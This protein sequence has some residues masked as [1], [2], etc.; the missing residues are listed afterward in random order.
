MSFATIEQMSARRKGGFDDVQVAQNPTSDYNYPYEHPSRSGPAWHPRQWGRKTRIGVGVGLVVLLVVVIVGAVVGSEKNRYPAYSKLQYALKDSY[1]GPTFYDNFDYFTGYDPTHGFVHYVD[2]PGA[3]AAN[4]TFASSSSAILKVDA[5]EANAITGRR[6]ARVTSKQQYESGLFIFDIL[7][8]PYGCGTWPAVWLTDP[9][10]WPNNGEID[11]IEAVNA[12]T[13]GNQ[14]ALHTTDGCKMNVKRKMT[15]D[16]LSGNCYNGTDD[17]KGCAVGGG[18]DT[19]GEEFN[20]NRG[21]VYAIEWRT[22]GIR[23]WFFPRSSIPTDISAGVS[24]D[25]SSWGTAL[26]DFP[27]THC[28]MG[29]HFANQSIVANIDLCGDWAGQQ[30]IFNAD[31][32]C[33]GNCTAFVAANP[34]AFNEAYW[35]FQ[36]FKVYEAK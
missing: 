12:A 14:M 22:D 21:G 23:V 16:S 13:S 32:A 10:V 31:G 1:A 8:S 11:V 24:P 18:S 6:S 30:K 33:P 3:V 34:T 20:R 28:S 2:Q 9:S 36:S 25:P 26:A 35:E 29:A 27:S 5:T 17:N 19:F 7:H 4:I 15:G